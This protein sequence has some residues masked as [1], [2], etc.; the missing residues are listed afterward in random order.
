MP[1]FVSQAETTRL[2]E[3]IVKAHRE[4]ISEEELARELKLV[5]AWAAKTTAEYAALRLILGGEME[6]RPL[7]SGEMLFVRARA[8]H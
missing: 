5:L 3:A 4:A 7:A 2:A 8:V 1:Q 6:V